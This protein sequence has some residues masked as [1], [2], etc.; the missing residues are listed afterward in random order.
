MIDSAPVDPV[1]FQLQR[2]ALLLRQDIIKM[3]AHAQSG[4]SAGALGM[5]DIFAALY[6]AELRY[7]PHQ[8]KWPDRDRLILSAG[9]IC[10]VLYAALAQADFFP[11]AELQT[12]R[13]LG[14]R[15]QGHPSRTYLPGIENSS[16]PLG[17]GLSQAIVMSLAAQLDQKK[18]RVYCVLSD[19]EHDEGQTWEAVL[20]AGKRK[21]D[22]LLAIVDRNR[23]QIDGFTED[24]LPLEPFAD[25]YEACGWHVKEIDGHHFS[26]ILD[27]L[28]EAKETKNQPT[29]IIAHTTP[30]KGVNFMENKPE[31]HGKTPSAEEAK[32]A[33]Q[34]LAKSTDEYSINQS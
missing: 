26:A 28:A 2:R 27:A 25:K 21:L 9:H 12:L 10:P 16:G 14:S 6:F 3:L 4:H 17:Q 24:V 22:N 23:I 33:L 19:G 8:P 15:L 18:Y 20:Y 13:Q 29:V 31:W 30:G 7:R 32:L 34:E 5:A 11:H 1:I